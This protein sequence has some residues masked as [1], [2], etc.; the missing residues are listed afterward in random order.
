MD[1]DKTLGERSKQKGVCLESWKRIC[2]YEGCIPLA[3]LYATE[4]SNRRAEPRYML[5]QSILTED[6]AYIVA[7]AKHLTVGILLYGD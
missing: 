3:N 5:S 6:E 2:K 4:E 1:C 7:E